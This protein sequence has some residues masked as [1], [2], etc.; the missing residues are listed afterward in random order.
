MY[1]CAIRTCFRNGKWFKFKNGVNSILFVTYLNIV[2]KRVR[3]EVRELEGKIM[4]YAD[5]IAC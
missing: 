3:E 4:V 1:R 2:M 5:N